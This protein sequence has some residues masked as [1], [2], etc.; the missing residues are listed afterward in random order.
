MTIP[1]PIRVEPG[2]LRPAVAADLA[3][4]AEVHK[5]AFQESFLTQLGTGF[6]KQYYGRVLRF[7]GGILLVHEGSYGVNGFAAGF[8]HP[9]DFY[10]RMNTSK[11]AFIRGLSGA[12]LRNPQLVGRILYHVRRI[13]A[14]KPRTLEAGCELSSIGVLPEAASQGIGKRLVDAFLRE[15]WHQS[16][17]CVYLTTDAD[18]NEAVN[19]FYWKLGFTLR[20]SFEQY[21]GRRMHQ[22]VF[23]RS[24]WNGA[25]L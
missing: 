10:R 21:G 1:S 4:V 7:E 14:G 3:A 23:F 8:V 2:I 20:D 17:D 16:A 13:A 22:Y 12:V 15:A 18:S 25:C 19:N 9:G 24:R 11:T 5:R 6:L